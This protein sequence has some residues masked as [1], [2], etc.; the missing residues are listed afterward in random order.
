MA[1]D[2]VGAAESAVAVDWPNRS[3]P[4]APD[5][6]TEKVEYAESA[7]AGPVTASVVLLQP[8]PKVAVPT[9]QRTASPKDDGVAP[10]AVQSAMVMSVHA[11]APGSDDEPKGHGNCVADAVPSGQ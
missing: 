4:F 9:G 2:D 5:V 3:S 6:G 7:E 8:A 1:D 10:A 11:E